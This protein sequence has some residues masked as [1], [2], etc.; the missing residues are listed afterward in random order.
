MTR[1]SR[2]RFLSISAAG[3]LSPGGALAAPDASWRGSALGAAASMRFSGL[4][5]A[6]AAPVIRAVEEELFR[7]EGIFSLYRTDSEISRLNRDGHLLRP[8][9]DLLNVLSLSRTL[10]RATGGAFDPTIQPLWSAL[11]RGA[12]DHGITRAKARSG[13]GRLHFDEGEVR[14]EDRAGALTLNGIAQ[15]AVTDRVARL[16]RAQGLRNVLIDFGEVAA[17]GHKSTGQPWRAGIAD[18]QG[19]LVQRVM[20][21][22]RALATSAPGAMALNDGRGHIIHPDGRTATRALVSVSA[23]S[24]TLADG[25]STALCLVSPDKSAEVLTRFPEAKLEISA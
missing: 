18:P 21:S 24:A 1:L 5:K 4:S 17:L 6:D 23:P 13:F 25:L 9:P 10:N 20:L 14:F 16:L 8:S 11:Q 7:L 3:A 19:R 15:G 12:D 2:R 22:D